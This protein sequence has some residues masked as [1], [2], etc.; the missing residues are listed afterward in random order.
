M[1]AGVEQQSIS[2]DEGWVHYWWTWYKMSV[3][4]EV[5]LSNNKLSSYLNSSHFI[6]SP[7]TPPRYIKGGDGS[8]YGKVKWL[9][10][11]VAT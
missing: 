8:M 5:G 1:V 4:N 3:T 11:V 10:H 2:G 7:Q 6:S 9:V